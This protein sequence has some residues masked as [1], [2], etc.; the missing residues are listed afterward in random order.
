MNKKKLQNPRRIL[1]VRFSAIGD[2]M[3]S[4][5]LLA[6]LRM[7]F[8][9]TEIAWLTEEK[10]AQLLNGHWALDRLI[11]APK[12]WMKNWA[13]AMQLR[14]RLQRYAPDIT[15]DTQSLLK[16]S[17]A[18]YLAG[19]KI[20][21]GFGG[22]DAREGSWWFNNLRVKADAEH[23]IERN[24]QL[25]MPFGVEGCSVAFD[26]PECERVRQ[27]VQ[28]MLQREG[29]YGNFAAV[30]VGAATPSRLWRKERYAAVA[31]EL[32]EQ[33]NLPT[34][35][36]WA[37]ETERKA[38]ETVVQQADGAAI[39]APDTSLAELVSICRR[40]TLFI[41]SDTG[42]LHIAVAAGTRC[43]SLHG[44]TSARR[45]GA[46]G[47][48][49]RTV[50]KEF[51]GK[52]NHRHATREAMDAITVQDVCGICDEILSEINVPATVQLP[53]RIKQAA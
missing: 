38:A 15:I 19:A 3:H 26:L 17:V 48:Q 9:N 25:L 1:I 18:A 39:L 23:I 37:G 46:Y 32:L 43:I 34:L 53:E 11:L 30:N 28:W 42:P 13:G 8:P 24:L 49:N 2:V 36:L 50:Q 40:A 35:V 16:S 27:N 52:V 45:S 29:L 4:V 41:G 22:S 10:N 14:N 44:S 5:P 51:S 31:K 20:R 47:H 12:R 6:A 7:R 33:W 21:I